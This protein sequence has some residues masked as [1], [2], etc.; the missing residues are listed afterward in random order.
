MLHL[1]AAVEEAQQTPHR[2]QQAGQTGTG[3]GDGGIR[4]TTGRGSRSVKAICNIDED[5]EG[6]EGKEQIEIGA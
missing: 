4:R 1:H 3:E 5:N 2:V 6:N